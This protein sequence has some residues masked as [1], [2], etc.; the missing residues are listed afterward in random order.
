MFFFVASRRRL[1]DA[2][3]K[4]ANLHEIISHPSFVSYRRN[5]V[6]VMFH[7]F[8]EY[9]FISNYVT[10]YFD[11]IVHQ[12]LNY[13][14][15]QTRIITK[16]ANEILDLDK[17]N[18]IHQQQTLCNYKKNIWKVLTDRPMEKKVFRDQMLIDLLRQRSIN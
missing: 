3:Q 15:Y 1:L 6:T 2:D 16:S 13:Y 18:N 8:Y 14:L 11:I 5:L 9:F 4:K 10:E 12:V 17:D 7:L